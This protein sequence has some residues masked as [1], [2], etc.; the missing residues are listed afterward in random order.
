MPTKVIEY[1]AMTMPV[2]VTPLPL[3]V[4]LVGRVEA[5]IVVPWH[6]PVAVVD[7]VLMLRDDPELVRRMGRNGYREASEHHD[8]R[9]WSRSFVEILASFATEVGTT[10]SSPVRRTAGQPS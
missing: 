8:W 3:A 7:A 9:V 6:D 5:G 10:T 4:E 1:C 2:I